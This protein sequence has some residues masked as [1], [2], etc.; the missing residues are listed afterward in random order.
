[1]SS[2]YPLR[3]GISQFNA[4]MMEGL[5]KCHIVKAFSFSRQY[6]SILFPGKTQYVTPDDEAMPVEADAILDTINPFSWIKTARTIRKWQPDL[7]VMKYWIADAANRCLVALF[8]DGFHQ[9]ALG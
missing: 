8:G 7:L 5:G 2:F 1:M 4:S 6:P 9:T 3:G